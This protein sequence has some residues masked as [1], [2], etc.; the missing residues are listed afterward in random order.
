[1]FSGLW[2]KLVGLMGAAIGGLLIL[3]KFKNHKIE[4]QEHEIAHHEKKDEI[5][6][7]MGLAKVKVKEKQDDAL[8]DN[9]GADYMDR[10]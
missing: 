2:A 10:L 3:L 7:D 4:N 8:K 9:T 6:E 1:M 5:I